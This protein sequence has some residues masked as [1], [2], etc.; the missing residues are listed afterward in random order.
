MSL[1]DDSC[2]ERGSPEGLEAYAGLSW[3]ED[4]IRMIESI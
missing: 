4:L 3:I 1:K 2:Q